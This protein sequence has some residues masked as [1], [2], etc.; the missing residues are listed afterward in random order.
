M[1]T[2]RQ[3]NIRTIRK[4]VR[5]IGRVKRVWM[6]SIDE[7]RQYSASL[8]SDRRDWLTPNEIRTLEG[9]TRNTEEIGDTR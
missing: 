9:F 1:T 3:D 2:T 5:G 8:L 7:L 6:V 4:L